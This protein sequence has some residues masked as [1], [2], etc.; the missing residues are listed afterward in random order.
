MT[1]DYQKALAAAR[2]AM[3]SVSVGGPVS[4]AMFV[5]AVRSNALR[6]LLAAID[7]QQP[8]E[9]TD[10][11]AR[12]FRDGWLACKRGDAEPPAPP[13]ALPEPLFLLHTG[14]VYGNERGDWEIEANSGKAVDAYCDANPGKTVG[15]YLATQA[16]PAPAVPED[17][18]DAARYRWL[19]DSGTD[20]YS[21]FVEAESKAKLDAA[22]DA[23]IAAAQAKGVGRE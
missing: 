3:A 23:A 17:A 14:A 8:D 7:A 12:A 16:P 4:D 1:T 22:I 15:L 13:A 20:T 10:E 5:L 2:E 11:Y 19:V 18:R 9:V 6:K 21:M